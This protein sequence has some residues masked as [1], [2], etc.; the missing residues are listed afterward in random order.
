MDDT[1]PRGNMIKQHEYERDRALR[2]LK[3]PE[4]VS[5]KSA[6]PARK[7]ADYLVEIGVDGIA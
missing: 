1:I 7:H 6:L 3:E 4:E 2:G 5:E